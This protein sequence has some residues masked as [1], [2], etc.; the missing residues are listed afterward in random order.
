MEDQN[1]FN[2]IIEM[3]EP[4]CTGPALAGM[5]QARTVEQP[6]LPQ[7]RCLPTWR[8]SDHFKRFPP[9]VIQPNYPSFKWIK[10]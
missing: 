6:L 1:A 3:E 10:N 2:V 9:R 5:H 8:I 7:D 4:K